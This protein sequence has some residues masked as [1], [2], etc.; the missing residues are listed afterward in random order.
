V[1]LLQGLSRS[2]TESQNVRGWK[3]PLWVIWSNPLPKE[4][5]LQ[6]AAQDRVQADLEFISREGVSTTSLGSLG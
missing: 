6:Q 4:S 1:A 3:G 2:I 5:H